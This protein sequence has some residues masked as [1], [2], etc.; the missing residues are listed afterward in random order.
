MGFVAFYFFGFVEEYIHACS[1]LVFLIEDEKQNLS[2]HLR[3]AVLHYQLKTDLFL[4]SI[5]NKDLL[6]VFSRRRM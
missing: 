3:S 5:E 2:L 4:F 1:I 6:F